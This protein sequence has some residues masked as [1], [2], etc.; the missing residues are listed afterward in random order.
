[1]SGVSTGCAVGPVAEFVDPDKAAPPRG[2]SLIGAPS[3]EMALD[4]DPLY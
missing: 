2:S 3:V 4:S 1:V